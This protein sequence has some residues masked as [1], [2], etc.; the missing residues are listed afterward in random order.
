M[1]PCDGRAWDKGRADVAHVHARSFSRRHG[2]SRVERHALAIH[3]VIHTYWRCLSTHLST[4]LNGGSTANGT[5]ALVTTRIT[6][7][8]FH[9]PT[10]LSISRP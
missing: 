8:C 7:R 6:C 9:P 2:R 10:P 5:R 4:S 1:P 3:T